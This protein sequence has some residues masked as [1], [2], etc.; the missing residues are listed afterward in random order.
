MAA[1]AQVIKRDMEGICDNPPPPPPQ[2]S[3]TL[4]RKP[5]KGTLKQRDRMLKCRSP[6]LMASSRCVGGKGSALLN[7]RQ[8]SGL[9]VLQGQ[10]VFL[11]SSNIN[12]LI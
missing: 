10:L 11:Y 1:D 6:Q 7:G 9:T 3:S 5:W 2:K 12:F 4:N 8:A